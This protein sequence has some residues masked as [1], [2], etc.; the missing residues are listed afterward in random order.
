[1]SDSHNEV[2]SGLWNDEI[3]PDGYDAKYHDHILEQYK[4]C[5]EMADRVSAR[6][7]WANAFFLTLHTFII[8]VAGFLL[9]E[10]IG[11]PQKWV[12]VIPLSAILAMCYTWWRMIKSYRQLNTAKFMVI[13]EYETR[14]PSSP[15]WS[16]EWKALGEG[17]DPKRY[18]QLTAV[19][20]WL[21]PIFAIIYIFGAITPWLLEF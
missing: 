7:T 14:L 20:N 2:A 16:A 13:G 17:K 4:L 1:M 3:R 6:R 19:E 21:P 15:Y 5:V 8:G 10:G 11:L 18:R 9:K 12:I